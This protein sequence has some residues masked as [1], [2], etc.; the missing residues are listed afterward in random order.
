MSRFMPL[1][2]GLCLG[3]CTVII[4]SNTSG[5]PF[6]S[7][8]ALKGTS[9]AAQ[10]VVVEDKVTYTASEAGSGQAV[11]VDH[12]LDVFENSPMR[13]SSQ[14]TAVNPQNGTSHSPVTDDTFD[15]I[16]LSEDK[17]HNSTLG[18]IVDALSDL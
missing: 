9:Q 13:N 6:S 3:A 11:A 14:A 5:H 12:E 17:T 15:Y 10:N 18:L 4:L 1:L 16:E 7:F 2:W 8:S